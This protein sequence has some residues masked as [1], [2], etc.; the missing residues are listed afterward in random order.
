MKYCGN[1]YDAEDLVQETMC[2]AYRKFHQLRDE[3]KCKSWLF[4]ILRNHFLRER[5]QFIKR[6][7]LDDGSSYLKYI[8][9]NSIEGIVDF[10]EKKVNRENLHRVLARLPEKFKSVVI[11][12]YMEDMTYQEIADCLNIPIGTVMSRLARGKQY[13]KK[14]L[15][16]D[17]LARRHR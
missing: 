16:K 11:L 15:L 9:D 14:G 4:A 12:H 8:P 2:T 13:L 10:L 1:I 6:P 17:V 5:R 7:I 3:E